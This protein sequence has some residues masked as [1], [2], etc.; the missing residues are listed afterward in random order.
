MR[1]I[2]KKKVF[3]SGCF[4]MLH[5]GHV[6]FLQEAS[7]YGDL[8]VGLGSDKTI[9]ELK[10]RE[11]INSEEERVFMLKSLACVHKV[12]VNRGSGLMDF[13]EE[14]KVLKPDI[15]IVNEDGNTPEK[16]N[17]CK[18]LGVRY[19][20]LKRIPYANL[21][22]RTTTDLRSIRPVPYRIDLAGTWIDQPYVSK[23]CPG[24]AIT[25]S[26]EP[27]IEFNERSG[28]ATS[29]RKK[30][31]EL[32]N[33]QLPLEKPEKL[34]R[35]LFRYDNDPGTKEV[36]GSQDSIGITMPG[37]NKFY[38]DK[39]KYWPSKFETIS[40]PDILKWLEDRLYMKAL[41]PRPVNFNV[42][43][44]TKINRKNVMVLTEAADFTWE[45]LKA[46]SMNLFSIGF[47]NSFNAQVKMFPKMM[48]PEIAKVIGQYKNQ[49]LAWKL[50]GAGGGGYLIL[51]SE[52]NI[53][54]SIRIKIRMKELGL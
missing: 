36:S 6:A 24:A 9:K 23:Y 52:K 12:I 1:S 18:E 4:D 30:A 42:L 49:A 48:N 46:K 38:Y 45:G 21:P 5:S 19:K 53:P 41:W 16:E 44:E 10:G 15:F 37:I 20:I 51:I 25:V 35:T 3:V 17:L 28:M 32:W 40:D 43:S 31:I 22:A 13:S 14:M 33:N 54:D 34:A 26:I 47:L 29:T 27:T 7:E 2:R 50:S 11:T 8:Y 39:G